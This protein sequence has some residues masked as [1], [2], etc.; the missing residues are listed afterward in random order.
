M[1]ILR[2]KIFR[3]LW[4]N[5]TRTLQV[6]LIIGIGS[7]AIGMILGT[8][9]LVV[10]GM[11]E[12]WS[13]KHP[14]MINI[15]IDKSITEDDV[16]Q[17]G[18]TA[19]VKEIEALNNATIEWRLKP[20]DEWQ[21]GGLTA[22]ID[23]NDQKM[24]KLTLIDGKWPFEKTGAVGQDGLTFFKIPKGGTVYIRI[25]NKISQLKTDGT[26]YDQLVQP[27]TFGGTA[28]FYVSQDEYG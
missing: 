13:S 14:A 7:A 28:Q 19:G 24:N 26:I 16:T 12:I 18:K 20:E 3:D 27:A 5:R 9:N 6:M 21:Q 10:P 15:F 1:G 23:Y 17:L 8:R 22:R 11:Q 4:I 25:D 2:Y